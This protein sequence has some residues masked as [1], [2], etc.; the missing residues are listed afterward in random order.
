MVG[1]YSKNICDNCLEELEKNYLYRKF[2]I[3]NQEK[4]RN[5]IDGILCDRDCEEGSQE[6]DDPGILRTNEEK[7]EALDS[8]RENEKVEGK[9]CDNKQKMLENSSE[10]LIDLKKESVE[11]IEE[12]K[13]NFVNSNLVSDEPVKV[14][15]PISS[16]E[17]QKAAH[18]VSPTPNIF[19]D[20]DDTNTPEP[21]RKSLSR[22]RLKDPLKCPSCEK[23]FYYK[24]YLS[25]H[26]KDV[27][28]Q[29]N[30]I[31]PICGKLFKNSRRLNS[32]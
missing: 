13:E 20:T 12:I 21:T 14:S 6:T 16:Q 27:H 2:L 15:S 25:F 3:G 10:T 29:Q 18:C 23:I 5:L 19:S 24:S 17:L 22:K 7:T 32:E 4:L 8:S 1:N 26:Y 30:E 9:P 11:I 28:V 31:C